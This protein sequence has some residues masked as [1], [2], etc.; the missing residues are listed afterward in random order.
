MATTRLAMAVIPEMGR[1]HFF[2]LF[3]VVGSLTQGLSP[4]FWGVMIDALRPLQVEWHGFQWNRFSV[5]FVCVAVV[6]LWALAL[7]RR[8]EEPTAA[9]LEELLREV[10]F[11]SPQRVWIRLW[12]RG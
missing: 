10:L 7:C 4:I 6:Y 3:S 1:A 9:S 5:F 11:K 2:A 8:L 12:P